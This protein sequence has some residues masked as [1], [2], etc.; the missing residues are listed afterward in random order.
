MPRKIRQLKDDL[1]RVG[2]VVRPTRG[3][4]SHLVWIHPDQAGAQ[5]T[6]SGND[7]DDAKPYQERDVNV[8]ITKVRAARE[9]TESD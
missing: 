9:A 7:G 8:A 6:L 5:L 3:K 1:R 4:G 2:F